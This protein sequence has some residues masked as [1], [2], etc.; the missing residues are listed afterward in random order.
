VIDQL[1]IADGTGLDAGPGPCGGFRR[2]GAN[3]ETTSWE[4]AAGA[5]PPT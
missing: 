3:Q 5:S 2:K 1:D 4:I